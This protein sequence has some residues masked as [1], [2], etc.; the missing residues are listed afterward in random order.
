MPKRKRGDSWGG[1]D[2]LSIALVVVVAGI[3]LAGFMDYVDY[4]RMHAMYD[5]FMEAAAPHLY[6]IHFLT[7]NAP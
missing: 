2:V 4:T 3:I 1:W 5:S 7:E 6:L